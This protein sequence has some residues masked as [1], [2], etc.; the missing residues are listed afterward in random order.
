MKRCDTR[1]HVGKKVARVVSLSLNMIRDQVVDELHTLPIRLQQ[2][3]L[4]FADAQ[5]HTWQNRWSLVSANKTT[6]H[7]KL[8]IDIS[9]RKI[10]DLLFKFIRDKLGKAERD[11]RQESCVMLDGDRQFAASGKSE[12]GGMPTKTMKR[13]AKQHFLLRGASEH[14]TSTSYPRCQQND[15]LPTWSTKAR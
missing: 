12:D 11:A 10:V 1:D 5:L 7:L 2:Q 3:S 9:K 4:E 14:R 15:L 13:S 8:S 6:R